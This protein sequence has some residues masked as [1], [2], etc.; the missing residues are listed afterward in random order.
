MFANVQEFII[1]PHI[2]GQLKFSLV[3]HWHPVEVSL[4][5]TDFWMSKTLQ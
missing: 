1:V 5:K 4:L 2:M 3:R